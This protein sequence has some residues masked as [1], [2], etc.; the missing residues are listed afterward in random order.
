MTN[1]RGIFKYSVEVDAKTGAIRIVNQQTEKLAD[2][3]NRVSKNTSKLRQEQDLLTRAQRR[4]VPVATRVL[5]AMV[6]YRAIV[7]IETIIRKFA[8]AT[9]GMSIELDAARSRIRGVTGD[10]GFAQQAFENLQ[11]VTGRP[12]S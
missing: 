1:D 2:N 8:D 12:R 10:A 11:M 3:L 6:A 7:G 9:I 5:A 4:F